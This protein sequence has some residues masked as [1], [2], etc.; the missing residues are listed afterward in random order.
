MRENWLIYVLFLC[1]I[2]LPHPVGDMLP[3]RIRTV[4]H[5]GNLFSLFSRRVGCFGFHVTNRSHTHQIY[6]AVLIRVGSRSQ[7]HHMY[8][9][10]LIKV[11]SHLQIICF[12]GLGPQFFHLGVFSSHDDVWKAMCV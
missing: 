7:T 11:G 12:Q 10:V 8:S 4:L 5:P 1:L 9:A 2:P 3:S 6:S